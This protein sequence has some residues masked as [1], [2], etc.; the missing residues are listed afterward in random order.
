MDPLPATRLESHPFYGRK[1]PTSGLAAA[2][3]E[4]LLLERIAVS[5]DA[6]RD[7]ARFTFA[8]P[9]EVLAD[10]RQLDAL[11][12]AWSSGLLR[13][14]LR[15]AVIEAGIPWRSDVS[16]TARRRSK[17]IYRTC[18]DGATVELGPHLA[19]GATGGAGDAVL[20]VYLALDRTQYRI[21]VGRAMRHGPDRSN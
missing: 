16:A 15:R 8:R 18:V 10:L 19:Y 7:A 17:R 12:A 20:R 4:A 2:F 9:G 14:G 5:D 13:Q 1:R 21:I 3:T 6:L 11:A